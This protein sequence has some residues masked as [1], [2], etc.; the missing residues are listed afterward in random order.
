M[1]PTNGNSIDSRLE[2]P[3]NAPSLIDMTDD[4]IVA[5]LS[6]VQPLNDLSPI[7]FIVPGNQFKSVIFVFVSRLIVFAV[8]VEP[9]AVW[10]SSVPSN[11]YSPIDV[12]LDGMLMLVSDEFSNADSPIDVILDGMLMLVS[13][14]LS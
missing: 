9:C 10:V 2:Q 7:V 8:S 3:A 4:G 13:E 14:S 5:V 6:F 11:A 1:P 12:T